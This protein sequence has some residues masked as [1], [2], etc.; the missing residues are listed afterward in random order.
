[1]ALPEGHGG[2]KTESRELDGYTSLPTMAVT[3][4][5]PTDLTP[6]DSRADTPPLINDPYPPTGTAARSR[7]ALPLD[8]KTS[9]T[10]LLRLKTPPSPP[11][12]F[13]PSSSEVTS[14]TE[15]APPLRD[16]PE[17]PTLPAAL[18]ANFLTSCIG[19][20]TLVLLWAPIPLLHLVGWETFRWPGSLGG[21]AVEIWAELQVVAWGGAVYVSGH[22]VLMARL[23]VECGIDGSYRHMGP[24]DVVCG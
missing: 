7:A 17:P 23:M 18:H 24:D 4:P 13:G 5:T 11:S 14:P 16:T 2:V 10:P 21:D 6:P 15:I 20:A 9:R 12:S 8:R 22:G 3:E 1:M 19:L